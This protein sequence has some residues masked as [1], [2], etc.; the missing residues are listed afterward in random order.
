[1]KR[2]ALVSENSSCIQVNGATGRNHPGAAE[3]AG[4]TEFDGRVQ[5]IHD[6]T[7][8]LSADYGG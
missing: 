4:V 8:P 2:G 6:S 5:Y 1:M 3:S 7:G